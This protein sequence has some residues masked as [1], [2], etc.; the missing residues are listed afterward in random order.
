[1]ATAQ[2]ADLDTLP[3]K[4]YTNSGRIYLQEAIQ[5]YRVGAFR[6]ATQ[7]VWQA[8]V[9]DYIE[10]LE[11]LALNNDAFAKDKIVEFRKHSQNNNTQKLLE[12]ERNILH[13]LRTE[14]QF[15]SHS[16]EIDLSRIRDD[17]H[18]CSHP[19]FNFDEEPYSPRP[20]QVRAHISN[21]FS[22]L[23]EQPPTYGKAALE[24]LL[25]YFSSAHFPDDDSVAISRLKKSALGSPRN[26]LISNLVK[27][28]LKSSFEGNL[29]TARH[30][31]HKL[32]L[33][34]Q[35][36]RAPVMN[37]LNNE[38]EKIYSKAIIDANFHKMVIFAGII[39][40]VFGLLSP[41]SK[42]EVIHGL[43]KLINDQS[44]VAIGESLSGIILIPELLEN[45]E[46][47][48]NKLDLENL[49]R[50]VKET[51]RPL[52][53]DEIVTRYSRSKSYTETGERAR[54]LMRLSKELT[55]EH[56]QI[57]FKSYADNYQIRNYMGGKDLIENLLVNRIIEESQMK[58]LLNTHALNEHF[59]DAWIQILIG[60]RVP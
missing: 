14:L 5:C 29:P 22:I 1:M 15:I 52:F 47:N 42:V 32:S 23:L 37:C 58:T 55:S 28:I 16:E 48:R 3:Q 13:E 26:S 50:L 36:H 10:K 9:F 57:I 45:L 25:N 6:A 60:R 7:S 41:N 21:A 46:Q 19:T 38:C 31:F 24:S 33:I 11:E 59:P 30:W 39:P 43:S 49:E 20:E 54:A 44:H 8:I 27:V 53:L 51:K 4:C 2:L 18:R 40:E 34:A 35:I 12:F 56:I 17:R